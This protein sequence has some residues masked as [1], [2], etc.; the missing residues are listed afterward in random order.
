[1]PRWKEI[2]QKRQ[3]T[4]C[5]HQSKEES[6]AI[7]NLIQISFYGE[8][9]SL[10]VKTLMT[11]DSP[12]RYEHQNKYISMCNMTF[13]ECDAQRNKKA[14]HLIFLNEYGSLM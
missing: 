2:R 14:F 9:A 12:H 10:Q 1:M 3:N 7:C 11:A 5:Y 4:V 8:K 6:K 13:K